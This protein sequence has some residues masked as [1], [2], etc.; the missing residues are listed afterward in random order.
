[1]IHVWKILFGQDHVNKNKWFSS[2]YEPWENE[3]QTR[4]S[5]DPLNLKIPVVHT[6]IWRNFFSLRVINMW[7]DIP[8]E[9]KRAVNLNIFKKSS[10]TGGTTERQ[11]KFRKR[12]F[13]LS[14]PWY[15][16]I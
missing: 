5:S 15:I 10:T 4:M 16:T 3:S 6:E 9:I 11:M 14:H 8:Y 13:E 7:N 12:C 1:M 2:S